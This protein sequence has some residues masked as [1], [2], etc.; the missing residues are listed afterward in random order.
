[1]TGLERP[2]TLSQ[3]QGSD[4]PEQ[5]DLHQMQFR[6]EPHQP[7]RHRRSTVVGGSNDAKLN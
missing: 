3:R 2:L 1:M 5:R 7:Q 6:L 4:D